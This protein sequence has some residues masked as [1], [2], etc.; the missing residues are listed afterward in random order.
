MHA[1][2]NGMGQSGSSPG[3]GSGQ[4]GQSHHQGNGQG[5]EAGAPSMPQNNPSDGQVVTKSESGG[6][7]HGGGGY[8][9]ASYFGQLA[10]SGAMDNVMCRPVH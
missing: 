10:A 4:G 8:S 1:S 7:H 3:H 5:H 9:A 6:S 2:Y